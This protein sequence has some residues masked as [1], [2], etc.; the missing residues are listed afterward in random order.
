MSLNEVLNANRLF[1]TDPDKKV[2]IGLS[3]GQRLWRSPCWEWNRLARPRSLW[4]VWRKRTHYLTLGVWQWNSMLFSGEQ[5]RTIISRI[6]FGERESWERFYSNCPNF[7]NSLWTMVL[8]FSIVSCGC[9]IGTSI[10]YGLW[11]LQL[12][13]GAWSLSAPVGLLWGYCDPPWLTWMW[14]YD[15]EFYFICMINL[16]LMLFM[17]PEKEESQQDALKM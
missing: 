11:Y 3:P 12:W 13:I 17:Q 15:V 16:K 9:C 14:N 6:I 5:L 4:E 1:T 8:Q 10:F 2:F 7:S